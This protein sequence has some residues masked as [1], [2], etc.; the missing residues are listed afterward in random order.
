M[1]RRITYLT[2]ADAPFEPTKQAVLNKKSLSI[3]E[4]DA[5]KEERFTFGAAELPD[6]LSRA[7]TATHEF[8]IRWATER[9]YDS[10]APFLSRVSPGLHVYYTPLENNGNEENPEDQ[11]CSSLKDLFGK[12]IKCQSLQESFTQPPI[13]SS[14]FSSVASL[15][16]HSVLPSI[17]HFAENV[18]RYACKS[19]DAE[20]ADRIA[21]L[22]SADS[23]DIDY[24]AISHTLSI[25]AFWSRPLPGNRGWTE[26][27]DKSSNAVSEKVE[28]GLLA[29]EKAVDKED[30]SLGGFLA[31]VGET[32]ILKP[33]LFSFPSRHHPLSDAA[34][35]TTTLET[36]TGLHPT[37]KISLSPT[38][39]ARP[40][41]PEDAACALHSYLTLPSVI[42]ADKY[43][44]STTDELFLNSHNLVA[45]R[46][47]SGETDLEA[48]DWVLPR[49]GSN[50]LLEL[51]VPSDEQT[52]DTWDVTIPLHLR[53][54]KPSEGGIQHTYLP[55]PV[56][57]WA[58]TA[59][60]GTKM[61]INPFD[62][63]NVGFDGLFGPK[64][65]FFQLHPET[66]N[67]SRLVEDLPVPVLQ[68]AEG[69]VAWPGKTVYQQVELGTV[70][71]I[72]LGFVWVLWKLG[73]VVRS[74][75]SD[76]RSGAAEKKKP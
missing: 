46:A 38:A 40:P 73:A 70:V 71:A 63:V 64:T 5:A 57:F 61:G 32:D 30:L 37:L 11:L 1:K 44:L 15:Q 62:R 21:A 3:R 22:D 53:Y 2:S 74:S 23:V 34:T 19:T 33:T 6:E 76:R 39:L 49:W 45:L 42:F 35:Y 10:V 69:D 65:M 50:L 43:Q 68:T 36:P 13:L 7:L 54:L 47:L 56:V 17:S 25:S 4:L 24:D 16:L 29:S 12:D 41:A 51:A 28:V 31:V 14:R 20:C 72:V 18:Q 60:D 26:T 59:D 75:P 8:H 58:C 9:N 27:I 67:N 66:K 52:A 55:W 48:P